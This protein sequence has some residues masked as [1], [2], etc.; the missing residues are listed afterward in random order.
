MHEHMEPEINIKCLPL[1]L[2]VSILCV[3]TGSPTDSGAPDLA[4]LPNQLAP[5][6]LCPSPQCSH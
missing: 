2:S 6:H 1:P 5:G 4:R 3:E